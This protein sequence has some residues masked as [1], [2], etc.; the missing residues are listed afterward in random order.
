M[1]VFVVLR[2]PFNRPGM[3]QTTVLRDG[4]NL[5][6]SVKGQFVPGVVRSG[7]HHSLSLPVAWAWNEDVFILAPNS[8]KQLTHESLLH[9]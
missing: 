2:G 8:A 4:P 6:V 3:Q 5:Q 1:L 7:V 9:P